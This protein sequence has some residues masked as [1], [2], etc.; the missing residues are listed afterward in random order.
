M[1]YITLAEAKVHLNIE[2]GYTADNTYI[3]D[4]IEVAEQSV[5]DYL[6][7]GVVLTGY[8][9][10][11]VNRAIKHSTL[12]YIGHLYATRTTVSYAQGYEIP[13]AFKFLLNPYRN[14]SIS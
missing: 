10:T 13:M 12:L 9:S 6:N 4:L 8:T 1:S 7:G 3:E 2:S 11:T 14:Y 5:E